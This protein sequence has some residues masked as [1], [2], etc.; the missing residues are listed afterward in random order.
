MII[1]AS[2]VREIL[3]NFFNNI[4]GFTGTVGEELEMAIFRRKPTFW[5]KIKWNEYKTIYIALGILVV[6]FMIYFIDIVLEITQAFF[7]MLVISFSMY[8]L[9]LLILVY[10]DF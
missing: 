8:L 6:L 7:Y 3:W 1:S 9:I 5:E 2:R 4:H 10:G